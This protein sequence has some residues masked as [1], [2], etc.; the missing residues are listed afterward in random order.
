MRW[1][2]GITDSMDMSLGKLQELVMD[3][4]AWHPTVHGV[5]KSQT[6]LS[7]WTECDGFARLTP[8]PSRPL[9]ASLGTVSIISPALHMGP[10]EA[11]EMRI[12]QN[13][14]I[15]RYSS[16]RALLSPHRPFTAPKMPWFGIRNSH[17]LPSMGGSESLLRQQEQSLV[18]GVLLEHSQPGRRPLTLLHLS[19]WHSPFPGRGSRSYFC[20][21]FPLQCQLH[22]V[23]SLPCSQPSPQ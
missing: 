2:D 10:C 12:N 8:D 4:E 20:I 17:K 23:E 21:S 19:P 7:D 16:F 14:C 5:A 15:N 6:Q 22:E 9:T 13:Q 1:L 3:R 18:S 11:L